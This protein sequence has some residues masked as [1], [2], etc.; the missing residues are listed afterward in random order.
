MSLSKVELGAP[1]GARMAMRSPGVMCRENGP[2]E[3]APKRMPTESSCSN[4][5]CVDVFIRIASPD[6]PTSAPQQQQEE[7]AAQQGRKNSDRNFC[8]DGD[9]AAQGIGHEQEQSAHQHG[10][11]YD[12]PLVCTDPNA[13]RAG[14]FIERIS[15]RTR[16]HASSSKQAKSTTSAQLPPAS[17]P[18]VHNE[19]LRHCSSLAR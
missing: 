2:K 10:Q 14:A 19:M 11:R 8:G 15:W 3:C 1:L 9:R 5:V 18:K 6:L 12:L 17:E 7:R 13:P 16:H 4:A